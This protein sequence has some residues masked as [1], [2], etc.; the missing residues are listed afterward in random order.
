MAEA[1]KRDARQFNRRPKRS[2]EEWL[3]VVNRWRSSGQSADAFARAHDL[4][5]GTLAVWASRLKSGVDGQTSRK[6]SGSPSSSPF[7]PVRV[8]SKSAPRDVWTE[9]SVAGGFE[10]VLTNGRRVR[11]AG[12]FRPE[13]LAQ[14]LAVV[15]GGAAC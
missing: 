10:V 14:L 6:S 13:S 4:H 5:P 12:T 2:P 11:V 15:E 9:M 7:L 3:K 1:T 8:S